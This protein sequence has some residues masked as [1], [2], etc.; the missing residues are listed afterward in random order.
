MRET[1]TSDRPR[2]EI[3][4]EH[5]LLV[6]SMADYAI[7]LLDPAGHVTRWN[8]G[9][10]QTFGYS[11][12]EILGKHFAVFFR[13]EDQQRGDH[14]R[15]LRVAADQGKA[16]DERWHVRKDGTRFW[17]SGITT[18]LWQDGR[19]RGFARVSRDQTA[20]RDMSVENARLRAELETRAGELAAA[21]RRK[22]EFLAM[23]AHELRNPLA[24]IRNSTQLLQRVGPD[25]PTL[26]RARAVID[27]QVTHLSRL[28][29]DLLDLSR[30]NSGKVS[31]EHES[32][33]VAAVVARAA[34]ST[35]PSSRPDT[36]R[37]PSR[38]RPSRCGS[39]AT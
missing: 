23:L 19:L 39:R 13:P 37:S 14:E 8:P 36:T 17:G 16:T 21:D 10:A 9:A 11:R 38:C 35:A 30:V 34:R 31:L 27:R 15:E 4:E 33:D 24:P 22:D 5:R 26:T 25:D 1:R 28:V 18:A 7:F 6:E 2:N 20:Q 32:L 3:E 29:N 12:D